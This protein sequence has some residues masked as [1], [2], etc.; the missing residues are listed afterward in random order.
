MAA[1]VA[2]RQKALDLAGVVE[3]FE[4]NQSRQW[5][6]DCSMLSDDSRPPIRWVTTEII[7]KYGCYSALMTSCEDYQSVLEIDYRYMRDASCFHPGIKP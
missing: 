5:K 7:L 2:A 4:D 6:S 1:R 3:S